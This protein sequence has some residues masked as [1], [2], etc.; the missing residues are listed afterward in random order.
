MIEYALEYSEKY[1]VETEKTGNTVLAK[2][3]SKVPHK[4][5]ETF[6]EACVFMKLSLFFLRASFASHV[7]LGRFNQY[8]YPFYLHDKKNGIKDEEIYI[9]F[10][11]SYR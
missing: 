7:T 11:E 4:G 2:A 3:L 5:A 1:R 6:Y 10:S 9:L 8:M